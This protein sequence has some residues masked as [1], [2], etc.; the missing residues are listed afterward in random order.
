MSK[1]DPMPLDEAWWQ[2]KREMRH[3][4]AARLAEKLFLT[5]DDTPADEQ[6]QKAILQWM[7]APKHLHRVH[8]GGT[9]R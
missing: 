6:L 1:R 9:T 5:L 7:E 3:R 8:F 2:F 4:R